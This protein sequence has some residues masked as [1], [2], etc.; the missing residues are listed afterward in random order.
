MAYGS[1]RGIKNKI[2]NKM[3]IEIEYIKLTKQELTKLINWNYVFFVVVYSEVCLDG[4]REM[5]VLHPIKSIHSA[6]KIRNDISMVNIGGVMKSEIKNVFG[7]EIDYS[8]DVRI[9]LGERF[10]KEEYIYPELGL[11]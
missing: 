8:Y 11:N 6:I 2:L 9:S 1:G 10:E 3:S 4:K 7:Y 5:L